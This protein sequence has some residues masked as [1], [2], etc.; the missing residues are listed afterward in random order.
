MTR[1]IE[2]TVAGVAAPKGSARA[3]TYTRS[4]A[5]GGGIGARVDHDNP[6]TKYWQREVGLAAHVARVAAKAPLFTGAVFIAAVFYLPRPKRLLTALRAPLAIPHV[7]KPDT[8]KL[9]RSLCDALTGVLWTDD[10]QVT[11]LIVRKRYC[12]AADAPRAVIRVRVAHAEG[13]LYGRN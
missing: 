8:D 3:Y 2:F 9:A 5:K 6:R 10:A 13:G 4:A 1:G 12:G 11:D 7:S